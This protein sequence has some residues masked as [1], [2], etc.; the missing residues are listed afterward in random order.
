MSPKSNKSGIKSFRPVLSEAAR[1][2]L[3]ELAA[4]L[5]FIVSTPSLY[6]GK[7][8]VPDFLESLA[9]AYRADPPATLAALRALLVPPDA[10]DA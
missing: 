7:P 2:T 3:T 4:G 9:S 1:D 8:S 6:T 5:G 10:P